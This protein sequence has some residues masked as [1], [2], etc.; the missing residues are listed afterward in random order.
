MITLI[1]KQT[2]QKKSSFL[3]MLLL[4]F[5]LTSQADNCFRF[6]MNCIAINFSKRTGFFSFISMLSFTVSIFTVFGAFNAMC[7]NP[8]SGEVP[9]RYIY[10]VYYKVYLYSVKSNVIFPIKELCYFSEEFCGKFPK[11]FLSENFPN[12]SF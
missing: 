7:P 3:I 12:C 9:I 6:L 2:K 1:S 11:L 4:R 5:Y 8:V 10:I